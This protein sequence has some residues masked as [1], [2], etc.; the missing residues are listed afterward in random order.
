[1]EI[2]N[3]SD[4]FHIPLVIGRRYAQI[5][6]FDVGPIK[7]DDYAKTGK[8]ASSTQSLEELQDKWHPSMMLPKMY[9]DREIH[10][11]PWRGAA[12]LEVID[13]VLG[14]NKKRKTR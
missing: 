3:N 10:D 7:G 1:M 12:T 6:F 2:H 11:N 13:K 4:A 9:L 5:V 8:Y 14:N